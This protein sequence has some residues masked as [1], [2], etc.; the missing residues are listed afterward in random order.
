MIGPA[1]R[2]I[3]VFLARH[4]TDACFTGMGNPMDAAVASSHRRAPER[5]DTA[6]L[7]A[8]SQLSPE[9]ACQK[10]STNLAGLTGSEAARRLKAYGPNLVTREQKPTIRRKSGPVSAIR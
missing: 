5:A 3:S 4:R 7:I 10:L 8:L 1:G 6:A 2:R 9:P